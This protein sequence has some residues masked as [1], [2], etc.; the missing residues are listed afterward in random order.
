MANIPMT[1][2]KIKVLLVIPLQAQLFDFLCHALLEAKEPPLDAR[3][4]GLL[5]RL[6]LSRFRPLVFGFGDGSFTG[7]VNLSD[8][9]RIELV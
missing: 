4:R 6:M 9:G 2:N 5:P 1:I 8:D 7:G 3:A